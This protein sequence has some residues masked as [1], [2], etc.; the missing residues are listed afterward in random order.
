MFSGGEKSL[1]QRGHAGGGSLLS[2][3]VLEVFVY[4]SLA[5]SDYRL[6][7]GYLSKKPVIVHDLV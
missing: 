3:S 1:R 6:Q 4:C 5:L 7:L 2:V